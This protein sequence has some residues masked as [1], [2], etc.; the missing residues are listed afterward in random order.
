MRRIRHGKALERV[1][2]ALL[3]AL[4]VY[5]F[6]P[7]LAKLGLVNGVGSFTFVLACLA[8]SLAFPWWW[9]RV[10][11]V[12][13]ASFG[14]V[15]V[16]WRPS[17][18]SLLASL[19]RMP[20]TLWHQLTGIFRSQPFGDPLQTFAFVW[21]VAFVYMLVAYAIRRS[22]LWVFYNILAF[23]VLT[24]IDGNTGVH[25]N[26]SIVVVAI[27]FTAVLGLNQFLRVQ[28]FAPPDT[29]PTRRFLTP[30]AVLLAV[31]LV[32]AFA[33][34]KQAAAW[35][36]PFGASTIGTGPAVQSI[37]YQLDNTRLGGSFTTNDTE[38]LDVFSPYP[39]YLRGQT[40]STYTGKGWTSAPL[41]DAQMLNQTV[42][43]TM[44]DVQSYAFHNLPTQTFNET[45]QL[46]ADNVNTSILLGGYAVANVLRLP[47][48]YQN[49]FA[50]DRVQDNIK[51]PQLQAGQSYEIQV[52][53]IRDPYT[54]LAADKTSF[55][56]VSSQIPDE[57]KQTNLQLPAELPARVGGLAKQI[58][59]AANGHTE[60]DMVSAIETYLQ[61][62][63][64]YQTYAIPV[65]GPRQDYVD[66]F[67]F[68]SK[69]GYC[70]NFSTSL[71]VMLRTLGIPTRW[72]TGYADGT[73]DFNY[74]NKVDNRYVVTNNDAHSWVE[75]YFPQYGWIPFDPT[76]NFQI[77]FAASTTTTT[78]GTA[79]QPIPTG[80]KQHPQH[81][82]RQPNGASTTSVGFRAVPWQHVL[83]VSL[84][85]VAG[86]VLVVAL[87]ALLFR[88]RYLVFRLE[89]LWADDPKRAL[90]RAF[91]VLIKILRRRYRVQHELTLRELWPFARQAGITVDEY[92][93]WVQTAER[94]LYG[95][96]PVQT[97]TLRHMRHVSMKWIQR[98]IRTQK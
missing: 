6:L 9:T 19:V 39:T 35:P 2:Y 46:Q 13:L 55:A 58:V 67:L 81:P 44:T 89:R 57:V 5:M 27:L 88:N 37:G 63:D 36:N 75:V 64:I 76:P 21:L 62:N 20:S 25:P 28:F 84:I 48:L 15:D 30:L 53:E 98:A 42:G 23:V 24:A 16:F 73:Q 54:I 32:V 97:D 80:P 51:A 34:P 72:V 86:L 82:P 45:I 68:S 47:G 33:L 10:L 40:L 12:V 79:T 7:P 3:S 38:V 95:G 94:V 65:P 83:D 8:L 26:A 29:G 11:G 74:T 87:F 91:A 96:E 50:V 70:N 90:E 77:P 71:A 61:A 66:E 93:A 56:S 59:E 60:Y 17:G 69:K 1:T 22:R 43:Q 85:T 52:Q 14:Y 18:Q 41:T 92:Q 78:G 4:W 49:Q 31:S